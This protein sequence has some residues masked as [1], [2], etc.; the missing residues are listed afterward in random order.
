MIYDRIENIGR[1]RGCLRGLDEVIRFIETHELACL[2]M[3]K[4]EIDEAR[5]YV[6]RFAYETTPL[7]AEASFEAHYKYLDLHLVL[8][9][10]EGTL[11][12]PI[13]QLTLLE[14]R[15]AEDV[16]FYAAARGGLLLPQEAGRFVLVYP[17]EGHIPHVAL[18]APAPVE[19]LVFKIA[20]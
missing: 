18:E 19:K 17:D 6:N 14:D 3:G 8:S 15:P 5:V 20:L 16:A 11:V 4:T 12:A 9:G 2:P 10:R 13:A 7:T 1:Y